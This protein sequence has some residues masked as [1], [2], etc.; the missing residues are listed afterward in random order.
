MTIDLQYLVQLLACPVCRS[1]LTFLGGGFVC[2]SES[3]RL[4]FDVKDNIPVMLADEAKPLELSD[5][6]ASVGK[7]P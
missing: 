7:I 3:C 1:K 5:W 6:S 4:R 2:R